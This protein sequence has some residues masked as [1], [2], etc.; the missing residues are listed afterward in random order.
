MKAICVFCGSSF[1][2]R[3][4]YSQGA[5]ETG[6]AIAQAGL[7]LIYGGAKVGL[8]G[9]VA[10]HALAAGGEVIGVLPKALQEK[11]LAHEGLSALHIVSS[12][13][14]RK[15]LMAQLSDSFIALPGGAGTLE[16]LFEVWTW[17]QLGFHSK[18]C[19]FLNVDGY[20]DQLIGFLDH[21]TSE[22]FMKP[23][24]RSMVQVAGDPATLIDL[25]QAYEPPKT[26]KWIEK[27][28]T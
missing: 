23:V 14:E 18:P 9:A 4:S 15:A 17:G 12:M 5:A 8:M 13:H 27:N 26:P 7:T 6:R 22:G 11:E 1:G 28:E 24:M 3:D 19:G 20:Y 25:F 10:D 16:E 2:N 21:Q